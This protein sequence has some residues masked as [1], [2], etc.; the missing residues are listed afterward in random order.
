[1]LNVFTLEQ[2]E[3]WNALVHSFRDYDVYWLN[4]YVK[5]FQLHGDGE[6]LL[7]YY[8][9]DLIKGMQVVMKRDIAKDP[10]LAQK[11]VSNKWFDF[12]T[13]YGYGGWLLEAKDNEQVD[14]ACVNN[15][16]QTYED[17]CYTHNIVSEFVR[18][19]PVLKNHVFV[20][21]TYEVSYLGNVIVMDIASED[22]IWANLICKNRC[23]IRKA[24]K[25]GIEIYHGQ[26]PEIY[27]IFRSI[28]NATMDKDGADD[29]YYF[30][31]NFYKSI[32]R[33]LPQN[34]QVFY[35]VL[36]GKVIAASIILAASGHLVYHLSGSLKDYQTLAPTN[37]LLYKA[38]QWGGA[39][40]CRTFLLGGGVEATEDSLYKFK[41]SFIRSEP[42]KYYIGKKIFIDKKYTELCMVRNI[43]C[44]SE[45]IGSTHYF[46]EYRI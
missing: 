4:G 25:S 45:S 23:A 14:M 15:L 8:E 44:N 12:A 13:P 38:A 42:Y 7:F 3:Q 43:A 40:G 29:Y 39:N 35:A 27:E 16:F 17:W 41:K 2:C 10:R 22:R 46:P 32:L 21:N 36:D 24:L 31:V 34:A 11:L 30:D 1:M 28:Y 26:Y 20:K 33:D 5:A 6:P 37:L 19:H 9:D 18:F